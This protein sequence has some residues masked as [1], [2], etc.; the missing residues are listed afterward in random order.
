MP[1]RRLPRQVW[2]ARYDI[3]LNADPERS[4]FEGRVTIAV[5]VQ[6]AVRSIDLHARGLL[7]FAPTVLASG[8]RRPVQLEGLRDHEIVRLHVDPPLD[9]GPAELTLRFGGS[10]SAGMHGLYLASD[11]QTRAIASQCEATDARAIFPCFDEPEFKARLAWTVRA[12]KNQVVL[13]NGPVHSIEDDGAAKVWRFAATEPVS[14]Y[15]AALTIGPYEGTEVTEVS[16]VPVQV[17]TTPGK[18]AQAGFAHRFTERL[19]PWYEAYFG[20]P[21]PYAK[22]DQ[23]A[24]PGFDAGAMENVG[25][26]LFR[27]NL[28]LM[29]PATASWNQEKLVAKVIAHELAHMWFGNLVTMKWWDDLWLNEAFAEWF[30]HKATHAVAPSY[31]VWN[32]FQSDKNRALVDDALPTTH[33]VYTKVRTP[34]DALEMFDIITYQKGC[35][36]MRMLEHFLGDERFRAG[37]RTYMKAF[38]QRNADGDDLWRHLG[39]ASKQPVGPLMRTW[40]DQPGFPLVTVGADGP[41]LHLRQ[42][43]FFSRPG[44]EDSGQ[45]WNVPMVVRFEDDEGLKT[46]RFIF[47]GAA[48]QERLPAR[49]AL[50]WCY[51]NASEIGFYRVQLEDPL[52]DG[53]LDRGRDHLETVEKMGFIE[54][55]WALVRSGH[56]PI[57]RFVPVLDSFAETRDH[58][59]AR[60]VVDRYGALDGLLERSGEKEARAELHRRIAELFW[61]HIHLLGYEP[62]ADEPQNDVQLR[63]LA[64]YAVAGLA[65]HPEA[66][67][68]C[69]MWADRER[70]DPPSVDANLAGTFLA[71]AARYGDA[72]RYNLWVETYRSRKA[73]GAPPQAVLRYL[74]TLSAFR[75]EALVERTLAHLGDGLVPQESLGT[76]LAQLFQNPDGRDAAWDHLKAHWPEIRDGVGDMGLSR[77]VEAVGRLDSHRR[78]DVVRFFEDHAPR[79]AERALARG[80]ESMD[81]R[82]ELSRRILP[83]LVAALTPTSPTR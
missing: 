60:A 72:D 47:D 57:E 68:A 63:A 18:R 80:L 46:H 3:E 39:R 74:Y 17:W 52:L 73:G 37:I 28:L 23:V 20:V 7:V 27:Q 40:I 33:A 67:R 82:E 76:V 59:V 19:I 45:I 43:R 30:A 35:A 25:L 2:P 15:L 49:G 61:P 42:H 53:L 83:S 38:S 62:R 58:N 78:P 16:G 64:I 5:Q 75:N 1:H 31:F 32:D 65:G 6:K 14:S 54:D 79:A 44:S 69:E 29:D 21:Y 10:L 81:Q 55:Q 70:E 8:Q 77:V 26:V 22:Y 50:R 41:T 34:E 4:E 51:P 56:R 24:V 12:P 11:G 71:V 66:I 48:G 36:V 13:A 9:P